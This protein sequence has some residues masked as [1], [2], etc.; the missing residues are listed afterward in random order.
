[1]QLMQNQED[2]LRRTVLRMLK[3]QLH[4]GFSAWRMH[5]Q[6]LEREAAK[7]KMQHEQNKTHILRKEQAIASMALMVKAVNEMLVARMRSN[8]NS[9]VAHHKYEKNALDTMCRNIR[10]NRSATTIT[11]FSRWR[12]AVS[13]QKEKALVILQKQ[14]TMLAAKVVK[15]Q[16]GDKKQAWS[17][18][19]SPS[20]GMGGMLEGNLRAGSP[21]PSA[22]V[23]DAVEQ[24][25]QAQAIFASLDKRSSSP[26]VR[27]GSS[28]L[29]DFCHRRG[30]T[31]TC[32]EFP[33]IFPHVPPMP[34]QNAEKF[35]LE[36]LLEKAKRESKSIQIGRES[37]IAALRIFMKEH[38]YAKFG[39]DSEKS[40]EQTAAFM[41]T[42]ISE[43]DA[44]CA[45]EDRSFLHI[46]G[47]IMCVG[48]YAL[49]EHQVDHETTNPTQA[50]ASALEKNVLATL[51]EV[52]ILKNQK[53]FGLVPLKEAY[54]AIGVV[55]ER[56]G[57]SSMEQRHVRRTLRAVSD[58][59]SS[60]PVDIL[61][62]TVDQVTSG[63]LQSPSQ[64]PTPIPP[65]ISS[66]GGDFLAAASV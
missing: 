16:K 6:T 13:Q 40:S 3:A 61:I 47:H 30:S 52:S 24:L 36:C 21:G 20:P 37:K 8:F 50:R 25:K 31:V 44:D 56:Q 11:A 19:R 49:N 9:W 65:L 64:K 57:C 35:A 33:S 34:L 14:I 26:E 45:P 46:F 15:L 39:R 60:I 51:R 62:L 22:E 23:M 63:H 5:I 55:C 2:L 54:T 66:S 42:V 7:L 1:M 4:A 27:G 12:M 28:G 41:A 32:G 43:C 58:E 59:N 10:K 17:A 18:N 29:E 38:I 53:L 48:P